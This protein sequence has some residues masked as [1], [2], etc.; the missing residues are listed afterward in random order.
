MSLAITPLYAAILAV[1]FIGMSTYVIV[2]R[3]RT[4]VL[5][6]DGGNMDMLVAIRRHGNMAEYTPFAILM[7][8]LGELS[9]L[10]ATW[11]HVAGVALVA[12]RLVHPFGV[13]KENSPL[14]PRVAGVLATF[15]AM[16]IPGIYILS[17]A[18]T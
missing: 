13:A 2:T 9:G 18:F 5:V 8:A 16:L 11:L 17:A 7:M 10:G 3:A 14:A 6:G 1:F 12:G 4:D 15:A